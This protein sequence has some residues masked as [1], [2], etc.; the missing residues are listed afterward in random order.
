MLNATGFV[1]DSPAKVV[2]IEVVHLLIIRDYDLLRKCAV[3]GIL[4]VDAE[5]LSLTYSLCGYSYGREYD[6]WPIGVSDYILRLLQ[7][8][9]SLP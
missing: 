4:R 5:L 3:F 7:F 6:D 1:T 9:R 8:P 2:T